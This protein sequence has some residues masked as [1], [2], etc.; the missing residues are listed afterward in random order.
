MLGSS[1]SLTTSGQR[2]HHFVPLSCSNKD[3]ATLHPVIAALHMIQN[4]ICECCGIIGHKSD[5]CIIRGPKFLPPSLRK[6]IN[7]LNAYHGDE[8][9]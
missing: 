1:T 7:Q 3:E 2:S 8:Q 6:K 5:A 4:S 9:K